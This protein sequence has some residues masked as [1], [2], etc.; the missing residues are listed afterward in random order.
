MFDFHFDF[1]FEKIRNMMNTGPEKGFVSSFLIIILITLSLKQC[2][3]C[4]KHIVSF[5]LE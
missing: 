5:K 4:Q 1:D 3:I 2:C